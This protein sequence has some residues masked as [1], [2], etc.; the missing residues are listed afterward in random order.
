MSILSEY[1]M[2]THGLPCRL[3]L[4]QHLLDEL[5][6]ACH[7]TD[8]FTYQHPLLGT[9]LQQQPLERQAGIPAGNGGVAKRLGCGQAQLEHPTVSLQHP[10]CAPEQL[11][12]GAQLFGGH[13]P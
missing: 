4:G 1:R 2:F 3:Q 8:L 13:P 6:K 7:K 5:M 10:W 12:V 9:D 11:H